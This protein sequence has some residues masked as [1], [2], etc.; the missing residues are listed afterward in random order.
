[1]ANRCSFAPEDVFDPAPF[2]LDG[3]L[4]PVFTTG[5]GALL[6]GDC[7]DLLPHIR[8]E[9]VDTVF[10]DPP[11]NLGKEYGGQVDDNLEEDEYIE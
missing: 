1:M 4:Q 9:C 8:D 5:L 11:F 2:C 7:R 10:C 6:K 3:D